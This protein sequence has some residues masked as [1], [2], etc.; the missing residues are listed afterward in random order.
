MGYKDIVIL[1]CYVAMSLV[2]T[3]S[4]TWVFSI[5]KDNN[6]PD[7]ACQHIWPTSF[8]SYIIKVIPIPLSACLRSRFPWDQRGAHGTINVGKKTTI[9]RHNGQFTSCPVFRDSSATAV[10]DGRLHLVDVKLE[11]CPSSYFVI[12]QDEV[13]RDWLLLKMRYFTVERHNWFQGRLQ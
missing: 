2:A 4:C 1:L 6:F 5:N 11:C 3:D 7:I 13:G 12:L 8:W 10:C 9:H